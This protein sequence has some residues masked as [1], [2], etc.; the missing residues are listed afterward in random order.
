MNYQKREQYIYDQLSK[1]LDTTGLYF[2]LRKN[3][4]ANARRDLF[5]GTEKSNYFKTSLWD[6]PIGFAGSSGGFMDFSIFSK[7]DDSWSFKFESSIPRNV[8]GQQNKLS[9]EFLNKMVAVLMDEFKEY[10][11]YKHYISP[12]VNKVFA[13][14]IERKEVY[15]NFEKLYQ[16]LIVFINEIVP[17]IDKLIKSFQEEYPEWKA[18]RYTAD[19]WKYFNTSYKKRLK[20]YP[21]E[22]VEKED[23]EQIEDTVELI[24]P[25]KSD[26]PCNQ[27]LYGPPGTGKTY[28]SIELALAILGIETKQRTREAIVQDY[29][30]Q[31]KQGKISFTTF[32]QSMSY[33]DFIEG[34]KPTLDDVESDLSYEIK[35]G[36]LKSMSKLAIQEYVKWGENESMSFGDKYDKLL[37]LINESENGYSLNSK[38]GSKLILEEVTAKDNIKVSH[39]NGNRNYIVSKKR[40]EK[41]FH[42]LSDIDN[43]S[44]INKA[45]RNIIGGSNATAYWAVNE[46]LHKIEGEKSSYDINKQPT[47]LQLETII[48]DQN[49]QE[50]SELN[51]DRYVII[52]DEINRGNVSGIFG[53]LITLLEDDKRLD[54]TNRIVLKL[55]YSKIDFGLPSNLFIIGTMNTADRSVEALDTALR[56]RF[57][58]KEVLPD[59]K[60][61]SGQSEEQGSDDIDGLSLVELLT[62]INKRITLLI[63]KDHTIG[64]SY[65]LG[66][67]DLEGLKDTFK[68]KIIPL[69]QEYFYN[70]YGKL[71]LVLGSG[72]IERTRIEKGINVFAGNKSD[73]GIDLPDFV[74]HLIPIN[75]DFD[76]LS[77]TRLLLNLPEEIEGEV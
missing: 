60:V 68:N 18:K 28:R 40:L 54:K 23:I 75:K 11:S 71:E 77:A 38:T 30:L 56:R 43:I 14:V 32:H 2:S 16:D 24:N 3:A 51:V 12:E 65:F 39:E 55:P 73:I 33:E 70:D 15:E 74:Y 13:I 52:I 31:R 62:T 48:R 49:W 4:S 10:R 29:E 34:I 37:D 5:I 76:I 58:F 7:N 20:K 35:D 17:I 26:Y 63:D 9:F 69:L 27:I 22:A 42:G 64:H 66:I 25:T 67:N 47:D 57:S 36:I 59:A 50:A 45:I 46:F 53:E 8:T 19:D 61:I 6:I 72:F 21:L 44:N 41:V 1:D